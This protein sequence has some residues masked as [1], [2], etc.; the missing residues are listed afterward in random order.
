ANMAV[1]AAGAPALASPLIDRRVIVGS[2]A[3]FEMTALGQGPLTYQWHFY[4]TNLVN[5][6]NNW[7]ALT[8][9]QLDQA[10]LY[11]V[12]VINSR[13]GVTS[14]N[15]MLSVL[16]FF[17]YGPKDQSTYVGGSATFNLAITGEGPFNYLWHFF[18]TNLLSETNNSLTLTNAQFSDA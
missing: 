5:A 9:V 15:M 4:G 16:P 12:S 8:N 14:S 2:T 11:S 13:G 10:G 3:Y 1:V 18:D 7:L 6:T 17:V